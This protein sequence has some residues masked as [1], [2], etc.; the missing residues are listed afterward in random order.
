MSEFF[1]ALVFA[2]GSGTWV[3]TKLQRSSG[4]ANSKNSFIG[5][6][7]VGLLGFIVVFTLI[8]LIPSP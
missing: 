8:R 1:I 4:G 6:A 3:Y 5:A 2:I 7:V